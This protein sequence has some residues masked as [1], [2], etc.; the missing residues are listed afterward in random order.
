VYGFEP[1]L[2]NPLSAYHEDVSFEELQDTL[3]TDPES[4]ITFFKTLHNEIKEQLVVKD[5]AYAE[6]YKKSIQI[7]EKFAPTD[8]QEG[9]LVLI[10]QRKTG[11]L[12]LPAMGP[13]TFKGYRGK[14]NN[15]ATVISIQSGKEFSVAASHLI[16][17][18]GEMSPILISQ[19]RRLVEL[20]ELKAPVPRGR[21]RK[22]PE[23][24]ENDND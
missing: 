16:K 7:L 9:D 23:L 19:A 2:P 13:F 21:P 11:G 8:I 1:D 18:E 14:H 4:L 10:K 15:H 6:Q 20:L 3:I 17:F 22:R 24:E 5:A 12:R